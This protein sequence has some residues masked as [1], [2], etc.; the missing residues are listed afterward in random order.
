MM[1]HSQIMNLGIVYWM[2]DP[3]FL[4]F[5]VFLSAIQELWEGVITSL[6]PKTRTTSGTATMT[7]AARSC[8][9]T[10]S[11]RTLPTFCSTSSRGWTMPSSCPRSMARRW[12][13]RAAWTRTSSP[14]TRSTVCCSEPELLGWG[15]NPGMC[16]RGG[17][18]WAREQLVVVIVP[19]ELKAQKEPLVKQL[20]S[21]SI[22][23]FCFLTTCSKRFW[24]WTSETATG[25]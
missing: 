15:R 23:L 20:I 6:M 4:F 9:R 5:F 24:C 22:V 25:L 14:T 8:T 18:G 12:Q 19:C 7:A 17:P 10:R 13:T 3:G 1:A 16:P 11:T 21:S 2:F